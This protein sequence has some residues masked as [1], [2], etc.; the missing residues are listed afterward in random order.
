MNKFFSNK[1]DIFLMVLP[2]VAFLLF[3]MFLPILMSVYYGMTDWSGIGKPNFIGIANFKAVLFKDPIFWVSLLNALILSL[4]TIFI[5]NPIAFAVCV[6]LIACKKGERFFRTVYFIPAVISVVVTTRLWVQIFSPQFGLL[7]KF[8]SLIGL[9]F[10][11]TDWLSNVHTAL[12]SVIFIA[13]WQGFG[14]AILFYYSGLVG[15]PKELQ[16]AA[17][18][19]GASGVKLYTKVVLPLM[20]PVIKVIILNALI[21]CLKQME[22]VYLSTGGGPGDVTQFLANYLYQKAFVSSQY[23]Y[24]NAISVLFVIICI[25]ATYLLNRFTKEDVGEF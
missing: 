4:V 11:K 25:L 16:E 20:M 2:G 1:K 13:V 19:D 3:A 5:Q 9:G 10:L 8:L 24:G 18:I 12:G 21:N 14:W 23:G 15:I 6:M 22:T 7:N 17:R